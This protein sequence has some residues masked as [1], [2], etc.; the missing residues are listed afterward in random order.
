[1]VKRISVV[2]P[3]YNNFGLTVDTINTLVECTKTECDIIMVDDC[4]TD[5]TQEHYTPLSGFNFGLFKLH[6]IRNEERKGV[7]ASWNV[8]IKAALEI[9]NE[10]ICIANNDL[11]F[12]Q[13]WELPLINALEQEYSCVSPYSTEGQLPA[14]FPNGSSR[15]INPNP[16]EILGCCFMFKS[17]LIQKIGFFPEQMRHYYGDNWIADICKKNAFKIGHIY[18]SYIHHLYCK[19]TQDLPSE[20][21]LADGL[22]YK[23]YCLQNF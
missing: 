3:V 13:G 22:E 20:I 15:H 16:I 18:D 5:C 21:M 2:I 12:T 6:Y 19:T 17:Q 10:F 11:L 23:Q 4:S 9:G 7:N 8:G 14:D 1:M